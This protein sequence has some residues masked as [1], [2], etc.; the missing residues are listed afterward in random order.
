VVVFKFFEK[1]ILKK[2]LKISWLDTCPYRTR[3]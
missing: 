1:K 2:K 3:Y